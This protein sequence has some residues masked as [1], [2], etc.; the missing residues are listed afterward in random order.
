MLKRL[1]ISNYA[2]IDT[3]D[4]AL[5]PG[6]TIITGETGAGKSILLGALSLLLGGR[7]D[8]RK[9]GA[10]EGKVVVEGVFAADGYGLKDIFEEQGLDWEAELILRREISPSGRSRAFINDTPVTAGLLAQVAS[11]L[12]DIHSQ[13]QNLL[14]GARGFQLGVLDALADNEPQRHAYSAVFRSYVD[15]RRRIAAIRQ[16]TE[17]N[18][19]NAEFIRFRLENLRKLKPHAGEQKE[20]ER[21]QEILSDSEAISESLASASSSLSGGDTGILSR[22][23]E[24]RFLLQ[25]VNLSLFDSGEADPE[26]SIPARI[27]SALIELTDISETLASYMDRVDSNPELLRKTEDRLSALYDAQRRF[28]VKDEQGLLDLY[29]SLERQYASIE[30]DDSGL[31]EMEQEL[32]AKGKELRRLAEELSATRRAAAETFAQRLTE[33]ARP[34]GM[35]NLK[36]S[37]IVTTG[38]LG[39]DGQD[40]P[41]FQCAF[42]KNQPLMP[43]ERIASGGEISRL[44]L[45]L[46]AIVASR[47]NLP[48]IV[49][50]EVDT[51][52]SGDIAARMALLMKEISANIQVLA[53]THLP[54]VAAKGDTHFKV[55]KEDTADATHTHIVPLSD[56]E[57]VLETARMLGGT[58][59][60]EAALLNAR[61]L[62]S[63]SL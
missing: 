55:Y 12:V 37:A 27:D 63:N 43:V 41:A 62:L 22:L 25:S 28:N 18:R 13:H 8:S 30:G 14:I 16:E 29:A 24:L 57:R 40:V 35:R 32:K 60:D 54:Q 19:E 56:E 45:C 44:M 33:V 4:I 38:K 31:P 59:V 39:L 58:T 23:H 9:S 2:L 5:G 49:F 15:L 6:L 1:H 61:S 7:V 47:M 21:R 51:G 34:L 46:K 11:R 48:T 3:L 10:S 17:R 50:D 26:T 36:F 20:L 52:V 42:N 53:I